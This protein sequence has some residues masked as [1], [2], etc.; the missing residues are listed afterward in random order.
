MS[1]QGC[2]RS[3]AAGRG[4]LLTKYYSKRRIMKKAGLIKPK[5]VVDA[6]DAVDVDDVAVIG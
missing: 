6:D 3:T 2:Q 5:S 1:S 4:K